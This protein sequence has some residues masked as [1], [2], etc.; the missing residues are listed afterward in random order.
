MNEGIF[1]HFRDLPY[2]YSGIF[3]RKITYRR[4]H[5]LMNALVWRASRRKDYEVH[6]ER[7]RRERENRWR[8]RKLEIRKIAPKS[9]L[10]LPN[11]TDAHARDPKKY[12]KINREH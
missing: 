12:S 4:S 5:G 1:E 11:S 9:G 7:R 3:E 10:K 6:R 2:K 8:F